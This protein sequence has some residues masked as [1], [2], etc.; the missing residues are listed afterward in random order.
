MARKNTLRD[1]QDFLQENPNEIEIETT[2]RE[3][4]IKGKPNTLVEVTEAESHSKELKS[5]EGVTMEEIANHIHDVAKIQ[6]KSFAEVW[7]EILKE[8]SNQD[9]LLENTNIRQALRSLR[10]N[11]TAVASDT[12]AYL[13]KKGRK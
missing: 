7:L 8:G 3:E 1:L 13:L 11:S 9:P 5:L 4:F 12:I 10:V 2:S 6:N